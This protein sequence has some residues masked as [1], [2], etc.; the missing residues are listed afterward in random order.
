L[1]EKDMKADLS[2]GHRPDQKRGQKYRRILLQQ[3]RLLLDS[4]LAAM[5]DAIDT[6]IRELASDT[7]CTF[8]SPDLGFLVT[9]GP[10]LAV[11][12]TFDSVARDPSSHAMFQAYRDYSRKFLDRF[13]SLCLEALLG[14]GKVTLT[15]RKPIDLQTHPKLRIWARIPP[16]TTLSIA[17][18]NLPPVA[19]PGQHAN[20]KP[21]DLHYANP[22][23]TVFGTV[24]LRFASAAP[25][26]QAWIGLIEA[27]EPA[28]TKARFWIAQGRYYAGGLPVEL[29][30]DG[31]Y[32]D[33]SYPPELGFV[34]PDA[35]AGRWVAY[36]EAWERHIT[37]VEDPGILEQALG[38][39]VDTCTRTRPIGQVK[40][41]LC[42]PAVDANRIPALFRA[43]QVKT[44]TLDISTSSQITIQDPCAIPEIE[45]YSGGDNRLYRFEVHTGGGL[46]AVEIKW[47]RNNGAD[48]FGVEAIEP[49][50]SATHLLLAPGANVR[51]GD[52]L[53]LLSDVTDL[54]DAVPGSIQSQFNPPRRATG[55]LYYA[56]EL[57][58][59]QKIEIFDLTGNS[60]TLGPGVDTVKGWKVRRWHG[61]LK[62]QGGTQVDFSVDGIAVTL[63]ETAEGQ[64]TFH[65]G[66]YWQYE[67]RKLYSNVN[68]DWVKTPHGPERIFTPLALLRYA[69]AN[70]PLELLRWY[71]ERF[72]P[73]CSL[74]ADD[75]AYDGAGSGM[76]AHT[77]Q[78]AI[79]LLSEKTD[80]LQSQID[81]LEDTVEQIQ[82]TL[83]IVL[84][85]ES[86]REAV[87]TVFFKRSIM[88][89]LE[90]GAEIT[91]EELSNGFWL[92]AAAKID[93]KLA[94][95]ADCFVTLE[96]PFP[97]TA[98]DVDAW[99][100]PLIGYQ[101][102]TLAA[103]VFAKATEMFWSPVTATAKWLRTQLPE[104]IGR[105]AL[106]FYS[107]ADHTTPRW[108]YG[109]QQQLVYGNRTGPLL[110][111]KPQ[112]GAVAVYRSPAAD[113]TV[114]VEAY[115]RED[116]T[117]LNPLQLGLIYDW[118]G[119]ADYSVIVYEARR[120]FASGPGMVFTGVSSSLQVMHVR[121][122]IAQREVQISFGS[123]NTTFGAR[124]PPVRITVS[125]SGVDITEVPAV[126]GS[127]VWSTQIT[128]IRLSLAGQRIGAFTNVPIEVWDLADGVQTLRPK[129]DGRIRGRLML[130]RAGA[131]WTGDQALAPPFIPDF[132]TWF[133]VRAIARPPYGY[134]TLG[135]KPYGYGLREEFPGIGWEQLR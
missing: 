129:S 101:S 73:L 119:P 12:D 32:P 38:G 2:R 36:L 121:Q 39:T 111:G 110:P 6:Q 78:E 26:N 133:W 131:V 19:V 58:E 79:D 87:K 50:G 17:I 71:D 15:L 107:S 42:D 3:G 60:V 113:D 10:L 75:I 65:P 120:F 67:A 84:E 126:L 4:D 41:A 28:T 81:S 90:R 108:S 53:E 100:A 124:H 85:R 1:K 29:S 44:G 69:D 106:E 89:I 77:V 35:Q 125:P 93:L 40:L 127:S 72:S 63:G 46:N 20:W 62:T 18:G 31:R 14:P 118:R 7:G 37:H 22:N 86:V 104:I 8:G 55:T 117:E 135:P 94:T 116:L 21:Y 48:L 97:R 47:S 24:S 49:Q 122:G 30:A 45:G 130:H 112:A 95:E 70:Q 11:F 96:M 134:G 76:Q 16:G 74:D 68:G 91:T 83:Q 88:H 105:P 99:G 66:D 34:V 115:W 57:V 25:Q 27:V 52:L 64:G 5:G 80:A 33:A 59:P 98:P 128:S 9:P 61:L 13:P 23:P 43:P 82:E 56:R 109:V 51:D 92:P 54:G 102:I 114:F 123:R 103:N 132:E